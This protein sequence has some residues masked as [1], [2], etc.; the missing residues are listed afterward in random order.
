MEL[1]ALEEQQGEGRKDVGDGGYGEAHA[2]APQGDHDAAQ[3]RIAACKHIT[4]PT[5]TIRRRVCMRSISTPEKRVRMVTGSAWAT[6][7]TPSA[8]GEP[9][10][11]STNQAWVVRR[12]H[13]PHCATPAPTK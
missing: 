7:T 2:A 11:S 1:I 3:A 6:V 10:R 12:S 8:A 13:P 9:V 5:P 4:T